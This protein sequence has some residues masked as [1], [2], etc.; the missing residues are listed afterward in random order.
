LQFNPAWPGQAFIGAPVWN[1]TLIILAILLVVYVYTRDGRSRPLRI[2]LGVM[3][4]LLIALVLF[5]LNR[6]IL[7]LGQSRT[8]PSVRGGAGG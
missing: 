2:V 7:T 6:P 8:E 5:L 1:V 4:S 3:R